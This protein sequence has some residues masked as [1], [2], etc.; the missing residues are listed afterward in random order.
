VRAPSSISRAPSASPTA[1]STNAAVCCLGSTVS[2]AAARRA[3][4]A[5]SCAPRHYFERAEGAD[6]VTG[7][8]L[9]QQLERRLDNVVYRLGL[10]SSR[11]EARQLVSHRHF[12]VNGRALNIASAQLR[13][14]DVVEVRERSRKMLVLENAQSLVSGRQVPEWL[15]LDAAALRGS[16]TRLPERHEMEQQIEEQLIVEFYSR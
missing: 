4:T 9:L 7:T 11:R 5:S 14:G 16:V 13:P 2:H 10:A 6:G 15:T 12:R 8:V 1:L 3:T